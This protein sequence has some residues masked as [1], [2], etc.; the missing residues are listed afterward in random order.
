MHYNNIFRN[1]IKETQS[2][3]EV[4]RSII[5]G[6]IHDRSTISEQIGMCKVSHY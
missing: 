2:H 3:T 4:K 6:C 5:I 1:A